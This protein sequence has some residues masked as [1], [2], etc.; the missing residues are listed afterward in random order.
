MG[1]LCLEVEAKKRSQL[2]GWVRLWMVFTALSWT[3]GAADLAFSTDPL[4]WPLPI[5][6]ASSRSLRLLLWFCAPVVVAVVSIT[7]SWIWRG[8][9]P[10]PGKPAAPNMEMNEILR[11]G[12]RLIAKFG[13]VLGLLALAGGI[14]WLTF[15]MISWDDSDSF[16]VELFALNHTVFVVLILS[17]AWQVITEPSTRSPTS[18]VDDPDGR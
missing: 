12:V 3:I 4:R 8:F 10:P 18:G 15:L 9:R 14:I 11:H 5:T 13:T 7:I 6:D 2:S 1:G 17:N 16:W